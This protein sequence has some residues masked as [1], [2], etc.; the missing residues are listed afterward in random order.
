MTMQAENKDAALG[1]A[2]AGIVWAGAAAGFS[3]LTWSEIAAMLASA[4]SV[5]LIIGWF[6][7]R[8]VRRRRERGRGQDGCE[9]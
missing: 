4:Y 1:A 9:G 7:D 6:W 8:F 3:E 5:L 2:K